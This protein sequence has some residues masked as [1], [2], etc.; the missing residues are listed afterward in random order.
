MGKVKP[1]LHNGEGTTL[2]VDFNRKDNDSEKNALLMSQR[3]ARSGLRKL[4]IVA[5]LN[6]LWQRQEKLGRIPTP[7][8]VENYIGWIP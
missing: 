4:Y 6:A 1:K 2:M 3:L 8:E 7:T 5:F